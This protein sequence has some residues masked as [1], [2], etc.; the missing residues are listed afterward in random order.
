[1]KN[2]VIFTNKFVILFQYE[3]KSSAFNLKSDF[4]TEK[5]L[6]KTW[7]KSSFWNWHLFRLSCN[8]VSFEFLENKLNF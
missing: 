2:I 1:M 5:L 7:T 8:I 6:N 3:W 4:G